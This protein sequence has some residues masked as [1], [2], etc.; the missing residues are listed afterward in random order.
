[1]TRVA[2]AHDA[3]ATRGGA[4][5]VAASLAAAFPDAAVHTLVYDTTGLP[6]WPH[7]ERVRTTILDRL[8]GLR[9]RH[10]R[11]AA[12]G[13]L[14]FRL[15]LVDADVMICSS[16]GMAHHIRCTGATI[17]YCHTPARWLHDPEVYLQ[18][19]PR[20]VRIA[21]SLARRPMSWADR[22]AMRNAD[23]VVANS[24][25]IAREIREVYGI[26]PIVVRPCSSLDPDG[27]VRPLDGIEP[28]FVLSPVRAVGYKR[29]DL[30]AGAAR[31]LPDLTFLHV[32]DGPHLESMLRGAPSN[33]RTAGAVS[34]AELR[35]AYRNAAVVALTAADDFGL[36][37]LE[38]AAHG[39]TA[40]APNA[41]GL[42]DHDT[43]DVRLY[44]F[45]SVDELCAAI[46]AAPAPTGTRRPEKLGRERFESEIRAL[47]DQVA[48]R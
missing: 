20:P 38:A 12:I 17:V 16:S 26:E 30:L 42:E 4:E 25:Q 45:G 29:L 19:F 35:W 28:G 32:G 15:R 22:N 5:R 39:L 9:R 10:R 11:L 48:R 2:I 36:V 7:P 43:D 6:D 13:P 3:L 14:A 27:E 41:R 47:V 23:R 24:S 37:P 21:A 34:D 31:A 1:M 8:P 40:V 33:L 18:G 46:R 44:E